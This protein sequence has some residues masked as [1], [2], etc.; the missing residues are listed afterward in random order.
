MSFDA[1][2]DKLV[3][4]VQACPSADEQ[5]KAKGLALLVKLRERSEQWAYRFTWRYL[6]LGA[7][8]SQVCSM[9]AFFQW[10][11]STSGLC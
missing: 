3:A 7:D 10:P 2:F 9:C 11:K 5:K 4:L 1:D 8:S 6:T